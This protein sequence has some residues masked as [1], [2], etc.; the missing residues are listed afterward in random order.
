[1]IKP[2]PQQPKPA[3]REETTAERSERLLDEMRVSVREFDEESLDIALREHS[4]RLFDAHM[5]AVE[6]VGMRDAADR[7]VDRQKAIVDA[8]L[9]AKAIK[10]EEKVTEPMIKARM[11]GDKRIQASEDDAA[12][13]KMMSAKWSG[14]LSS[15]EARRRMLQSYVQYLTQIAGDSGSVRN[16]E[17][18]LTAHDAAVVR[19]S[20][21]G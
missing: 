6:A 12:W 15:L 3:K 1:M 5:E 18:K 20:D 11:A 4:Q 9:R 14:L 17:R 10:D 8:E 16:S 19:A 13:W 7:D 2:Q 21:R